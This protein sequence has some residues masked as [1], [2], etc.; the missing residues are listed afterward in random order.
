MNTL[1]LLFFVLPLSVIIFSIA[2]EKILNNPILVAA[3]IFAISL[4]VAFAVFSGSSTAII[5][6][7]IY[8]LLAFVTALITSLIDRFLDNRD[9]NNGNDDDDDD[10]DNDNDNLPNTRACRICRCQQRMCRCL[11]NN[12]RNWKDN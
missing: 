7:I 12:R 10:D 4:I 3:I 11:C 9:N 8:G 2:L 1:L 5:V 6:A